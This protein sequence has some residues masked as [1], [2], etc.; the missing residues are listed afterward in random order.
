MRR[1]TTLIAF[2]VFFSAIVYSQKPTAPEMLDKVL[3]AV[4]TVAV[5]E[6]DV[7]MKPLGFRGNSSDLAYAKA[8]DLSSSKGSGSGF[9]IQQGGRYYIIT[10]AHVV[11]SASN[12]DGSIY[13]YTIGNKKYKAKIAGGDTFYDIAVLEFVSAPGSEISALK[14]KTTEPRIGEQVFAIGNPLG[15][16]PFTVT[17]GIISAKN[18]V[19]AGISG[20]YG[21]FG[22]LQ[23]TATVIWGNSG[24]P[25][26]DANG[27]V[28]GINSQIAFADQGNTQIW[29]PQINF[30]LQADIAQRLVNDILSND[31]LIKRAYIGVEISR[32]LVD[33]SKVQYLIGYGNGATV[34]PN[35]VISGVIP[36]SPAATALSMYK[37][38]TV[39][40]VNNE[41][42][43]NVQDILGVFEKIIPGQ[44][45]TFN[46]AKEAQRATVKVTAGTSDASEN[47]NIGN[48]ALQLWG[49]RP[50]AQQGG[51]TLNF[52][53]RKIYSNYQQSA[54]ENILNIG[55]KS[56]LSSDV[57]FDGDWLVVAAGLLN[58]ENSQIWTVKDVTDLGTTLRLCGT[59]GIIDVVLFR[60]GAD[61]SDESN[62]IS[63]RFV[64][65]GRD[66]IYKQTLWY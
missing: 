32:D 11:Q 14:F 25:L 46:L 66:Y 29:Q 47:A 42:V 5:Y 2:C 39:T 48:Y 4:V 50:L 8:L 20:I 6:T 17:D 22:F 33:D 35:P 55:K 38:Y 62:Y 63:K 65:S 61:P 13:V 64:L 16:Y 57:L 51:L 3:S 26:V 27:D 45:V 7:A 53:D 44:S 23:S 24:G 19:R 30:A 1:I 37:G 36:E 21:R 58:G 10:N 60:R 31:G 28:A 43:K 15:D 54:T 59:N 40:A 18:R 52:F 49:C 56:K 34:N 41:E 9:I 12:T